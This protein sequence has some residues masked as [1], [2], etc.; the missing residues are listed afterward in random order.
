MSELLLYYRRPEPTTWVYL[1]SFLTIGLYFVFHRFWSVRNLDIVLLILLAPGLLMVHEGQRR[2]IK[3]RQAAVIDTSGGQPGDQPAADGSE[4]ENAD[5]E[6]GGPET[7]ITGSASVELTD[8]RAETASVAGTETAAD[9][10]TVDPSATESGDATAT[11]ATPDALV[12]TQAETID[13]DP[14]D[15]D[16]VATDATTFSWITLKR[17]GFIWLFVIEACI[18]VRLLLDP[19]MVRR[20]LLDPNLTTGGLNFIG[21][22]L[23]VFMMANVVTS[24]PQIQQEQGPKLGPGYALINMLPAIPTRPVSESV[25]GDMP[26]TISE[27]TP[28]QQRVATIAKVLA[29]LAQ[30]SIVVAIVMIGKRHFGNLCAG[31]GCALLYLL[32]PYTAQMTG[33]V[34]HAVPAALL[35]WAILTY[36]KPMI[37]GIFLGLAAGLVYYPLFLLPLWFSFYWQ[38]GARRF[39]AGVASMLVMLML[40]LALGGSDTFGGRLQQMFGLWLPTQADPRGVWELGWNPVWRLPVIVGFVILSVFLAIWPAQKN[41]GTLISCTAAVMVASQF[42]H[43]YGG[44][45]YLAWFLPMLLLTIFRPN[46]QDR[47]A[48][49]VISPRSRLVDAAS[50]LTASAA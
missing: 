1:S 19:L 40:L 4:A 6:D 39:G 3:Q 15:I 32:V 28:R 10:T 46:L 8:S 30:L 44:G 50:R 17:S 21:I 41:L 9:E 24:T 38:R 5:L 29:I 13:I 49:K 36:R 35:L 25:G 16:S 18:L 20:P 26:R 11:A 2:E 22:S 42:W 23:F 47:V 45:M 31:T 33:R 43:G 37:A 27:L 48:L 12:A 14:A 34:D 7:E